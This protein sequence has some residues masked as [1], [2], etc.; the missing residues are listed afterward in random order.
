[1]PL[2]WI[3]W[4]MPSSPT[5]ALVIFKMRSHVFAWG[6]P[7]T[8]SPPAQLGSQACSICW[9]GV[10][11]T[12]CFELRSSLSPLL[13][14]WDYRHEPLYLVPDCLFLYFI[15]FTSYIFTFKHWL[16]CIQSNYIN[17]DKKTRPYAM[18]SVNRSFLI[19]IVL[20]IL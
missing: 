18:N 13:S 10:S 8:C 4:A 19:Y 15:L 2:C 3:T 17:S 11:L 6:Q 20:I 12:F 14:S 16:K 7:H 9:D 1:L 5:P